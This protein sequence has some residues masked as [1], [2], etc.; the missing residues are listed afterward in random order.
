M[1]SLYLVVLGKANVVVLLS[2]PD[3]LAGADYRPPLEWPKIGYSLGI[4]DFRVRLRIE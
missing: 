3:L 4:F 1:K 2:L